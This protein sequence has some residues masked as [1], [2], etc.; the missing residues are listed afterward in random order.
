MPAAATQLCA[1]TPGTLIRLLDA[2]ARVGHTHPAAFEAAAEQLLPWVQSQQVGVQASASPSGYSASTTTTQAPSRTTQPACTAMYTSSQGHRRG[3]RAGSKGKA[4]HAEPWGQGET[5]TAGAALQ[6]ACAFGSTQAGGSGAGHLLLHA[7]APHLVQSLQQQSGGIRPALGWQEVVRVAVA[8]AQAGFTTKPSTADEAHGGTSHSNRGQPQEQSLSST[9]T[10]RVAEAEPGI[11]TQ[12]ARGPQQQHADGILQELVSALT[13]R[14][15]PLHRGASIKSIAAAVWALTALG[16]KESVAPACAAVTSA[17]RGVDVRQGGLTPRWAARLAWAL[18]QVAPGS[19]THTSPP[20]N[21]GSDTSCGAVHVQAAQVLALT[22]VESLDQL[23]PS[24]LALMASVTSQLAQHAKQTRSALA[25]SSPAGAAA[26]SAGAG[27]SPSASAAL[28]APQGGQQQQAGI[29]QQYNMLRALERMP[30][31]VSAE[32]HTRLHQL[33]PHSALQ[34]MQELAG[35]GQ[36][37]EALAIAG[38]QRLAQWL[39]ESSRHR[40]QESPESKA[41]PSTGNAA[42]RHRDQRST[43]RSMHESSA[44]E[45]QQHRMAVS[46][47]E[48]T[49]SHAIRQPTAAIAPGQHGNGRPVVSDLDH[50]GMAPAPDTVL[51]ILRGLH[52]IHCTDT[53]I[54]AAAG[55]CLLSTVHHAA[56]VPALKE[57][58]GILTSIA[59]ESNAAA[60]ARLHAVAVALASRRQQIEQEGS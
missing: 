16:A 54:A 13:A 29:Q 41:K 38:R 48:H 32:L 45:Q 53:T 28:H 12:V 40:F 15:I 4:V 60:G 35:H 23:D 50:K 52:T 59:M 7:L 5:L 22:L 58:E 49:G 9:G 6:V 18:L 24:S 44:P 47:A 10:C 20:G 14:L 33:P 55:H 56:H 2:C 30:E 43:L 39:R 27:V 19:P 3:R 21:G 36:L 57:V 25:L 34:L 11:G 1:F 46:G 8:Y 26:A 17:I 42:S 51:H 37:G 31:A